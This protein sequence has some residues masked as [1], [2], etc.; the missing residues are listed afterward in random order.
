MNTAHTLRR[1][2]VVGLVAAS[3]ALMTVGTAAAQ[4]TG[5]PDD[6]VVVSSTDLA[7]G[8][9]TMTVTNVGD[10]TLSLEIPAPGEAS[11]VSVDTG[12]YHERWVVGELASGTTATMNGFLAR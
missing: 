7:T 11:N 10:H 6:A 9:F 5:V 4:S 2:L 3:L 1:S 12:R 8:A